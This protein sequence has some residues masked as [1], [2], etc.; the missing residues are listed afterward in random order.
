MGDVIECP[1]CCAR[2]NEGE[3]CP[4]C[5]HH[6]RDPECVCIYCEYRREVCE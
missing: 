3:S 1:N 5:D 4:E 6:D 2:M